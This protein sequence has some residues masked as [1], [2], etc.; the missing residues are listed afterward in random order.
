VAASGTSNS[1]QLVRADDARL[2]DARTPT[3]HTHDDR[4]YTESEVNTQ[5]AGK[6]AASHTHTTVQVTGLDAALAE[7]ASTSH[8]HTPANILGGD[9]TNAVIDTHFS[10]QSI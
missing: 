5:M 10:N 7:K 6:A 9:F 3:T 8:T 2:S 4:Y 1:T